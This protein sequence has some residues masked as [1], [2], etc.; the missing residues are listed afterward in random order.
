MNHVT[1]DLANSVA[2]QAARLLEDLS[3]LRH[4]FEGDEKTLEAFV[5]YFGKF[6]II[7]RSTGPAIPTQPQPS[8]ILTTV[9]PQQSNVVLQTQVQPKENTILSNLDMPLF[10]ANSYFEF[11][12]SL[13]WPE[14]DHEWSSRVDYTLLEDWSWDFGDFGIN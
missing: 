9:P 11:E 3:K 10:E 6:R 5:P 13:Q 14:P 1:Q 7:R 2:T 12:S 4:S 8:S